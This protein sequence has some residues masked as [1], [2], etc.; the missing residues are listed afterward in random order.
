M[1]ATGYVIKNLVI[2]GSIVIVG[3]ELKKK[4]FLWVSVVIYIFKID[5]TIS[6]L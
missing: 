5:G 6:L 3:D 1:D 2:V 4:S